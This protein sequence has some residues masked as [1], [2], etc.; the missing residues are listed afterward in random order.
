MR[1]PL[2]QQTLLFGV[3]CILFSCSPQNDSAN[4]SDSVALQLAD[5]A[6]Q[7]NRA[8]EILESLTTEVGPRLAGTEA[9]KRA[10]D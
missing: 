4:N 2:V 3:C 6:L 1:K 7:S 8:W 9:D 5:K 10:V